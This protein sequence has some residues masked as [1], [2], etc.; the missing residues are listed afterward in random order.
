MAGRIAMIACEPAWAKTPTGPIAAWGIDEANG[1]VAGDGSGNGNVG[2]IV[3]AAW[4]SQGR[5]GS[6]LVFNGKG[7]R[8]LGPSVT[9]GPAFTLMAWVLN[10]SQTPYGTMIP[11]G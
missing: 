8:V 10:P 9:L 4:T 3:G 6:A 11:A 7:S 2:I 1:T 5:F